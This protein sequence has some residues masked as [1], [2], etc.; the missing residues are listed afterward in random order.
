MFKETTHSDQ[1]TSCSPFLLFQMVNMVTTLRLC[2]VRAELNYGFRSQ[3]LGK[4][5]LVALPFNT[6]VGQSNSLCTAAA[7]QLNSIWLINVAIGRNL[8]G[9]FW[10]DEVGR[11]PPQPH[12]DS[13]A[14]GPAVPPAG[15]TPQVH[16]QNYNRV[17]QTSN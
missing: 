10:Y 15:E 6:S 12:S 8:I 11:Q 17:Y 14:Y 16:N 7:S 3:K 1:V 9:C 5:Q 13:A 4:F 2:G